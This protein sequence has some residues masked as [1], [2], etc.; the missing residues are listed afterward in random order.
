MKKPKVK[1]LCIC[2]KGQNRSKYL[3]NYLRRKGYSTRYGGLEINREYPIGQ[4]FITQK[5][6]GWAEIVI[7]ARKRLNPIFKKKFKF[8][9]RI[10]ILN[11]TDSKRLIPESHA[12]LRELP[13][14]EF[15]KKWTRPQL[16]K[17]IKQYLPLKN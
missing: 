12:H 15:Q 6:V 17:A 14:I 8:K 3:A 13:H 1:I 10:I 5:D 16:R 9:G 11:V 7:L 2:A 4:K